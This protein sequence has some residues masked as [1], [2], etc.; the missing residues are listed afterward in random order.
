MAN[1][2][3]NI[4]ASH[5]AAYRPS[6]HSEILSGFLELNKEFELGLDVGC[7]TGQSSV[8][9]AN[10]CTKVIGVDP[11]NEM[12]EKS[13]QHPKITYQLINSN[14]LHF[15]SNVFN[16]VTFAGSLYYAKSQSTLIEIVRVAKKDCKIIIY[17]FEVFLEPICIQLGLLSDVTQSNDYDH[18][19]NFSGLDQQFITLDNELI[20]T[21]S[22]DIKITDLA[23]LLL[24]SKDYYARLSKAFGAT[25]LYEET[26]KQLQSILKN[27]MTSL[28]AMTYLTSYKVIK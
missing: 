26:T 3:D 1:E 18:K 8:A 13:L 27:E 25:N 6:L 28:K 17:D 7:G 2:Y 21:V 22:L 5:Y 4:T 12:L 20:N 9:L 10:Y 19:A 16:V 23:H 24:S 15:D 11:S 14:T